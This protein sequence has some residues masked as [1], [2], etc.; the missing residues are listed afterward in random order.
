MNINVKDI[1]LESGLVTYEQFSSA[2]KTAK[3]FNC[4]VSEVLVGRRIIDEQ[5]LGELLARSIGVPF[6][7]LKKCDIPTELIE[8][9]PQEMALARRVVPFERSG[10]SLR[11]AMEDPRN[12]ETI[13]FI[14]KKTGFTVIPYFATSTGIKFAL[15]FYKKAIKE[16]FERLASEGINAP[17]LAE[18]AVEKI[19]QDVSIVRLVDTIIDYAVSEDAS[20][21]HIEPLNEGLLIRYRIDGMLH[22]VVTLPKSLHPAMIARIKILSELK[23][24]EMRLPQDG[25][26]RFKL[27]SQEAVSLRVSILPTVEGEKI[28]LRILEAGM[29]RFNLED[30]G[31]DSDQVKVIRTTIGRPHGLILVTGPTGSGKTTTLYTILGLL[32]T[33]EVNISTV[34]DPVENKIPR[35]NQTQVNPMI[36]FSFAEGLRVLL[37]QDPNIIMVGEIRDRETSSI[38]VNAAMTGHL[39]LSTLHTNDA[40]GALPRLIDL[41]VEPFLLASTINLIM[42]QRLVRVVCPICKKTSPLSVQFS[43]QIRAML[44]SSGYDDNTIQKLLPAEVVNGEGC[45]HCSYT[46]YHGRIG[47]YELITV[48]DEIKNLIVVKAQAADIRK[49][50]LT[51]GMRTMLYDGLVKISQGQTTIEEVLRV[52]SE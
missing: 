37:R 50:A 41:G 21:I 20:D 10:D 45:S 16:E 24:D 51:G 28:V 6:V 43:S 38:A 19:A 9:I 46:G 32:N 17:A 13:E 36:G 18:A 39:V 2:E 27:K 52:T 14:R 11:V 31:L 12:L 5:T 42:A 34:E 29:Q 33:T 44:T 49:H 23:I 1:L 22:D 48:D 7:D 8:L 47:I 15:R 40:A 35:I 26:F 25:R 4:P 3:H 30:L